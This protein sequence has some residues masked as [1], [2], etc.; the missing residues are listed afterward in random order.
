M[1]SLNQNGRLIIV[2][3]YRTTSLITEEAR[4]RESSF[5]R[6]RRGEGGGMKILRGG[7]ENFYTP[8]MGALKKSGG[9]RKFVYLKPKEGEAPKN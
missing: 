9:L 6:T 3:Q 5:N 4:F 2:S 8:K 1:I 7:S